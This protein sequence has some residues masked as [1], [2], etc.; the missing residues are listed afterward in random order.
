[1]SSH[2][3]KKPIAIVMGRNY[4]SRLGMI[5]AAG[6]AGCDVVVIQTEH[7]K[8]LLRP[9]DSSS[10][11]VVA[12][13][14]IPE[15]DREGLIRLI[16]SY[17][18]DGDKPVLLPTDDYT[19]ATIDMNL[20]SLRDDFLLPHVNN[21]QGAV[22]RLMDKSLQKKIALEAGMNVAREWICE[23]HDDHY[24]IPSDVSYP[25]FTKPQL[26][27]QGHLKKYQ[28]KCNTPQELERL[29]HSVEKFFHGPILV[30]DYHEISSEYAVVG[31]SLKDQ[32]LIPSVIEMKDSFHGITAI[33]TLTPISR[34][35]SMKECLSDFMRRTQLTGLFDID[36]YESG[37]KLYFNELNVRFGANGFALSNSVVNLPGL[38]LH[39]LL[40]HGLP[41]ANTPQS[42][43]SLTFANENIL[44]QMYY[45][46]LMTYRQY[47]SSQHGA[48]T[49]AI[50]NDDDK[51]PYFLFR[52][53]D[54][55]L[56]MVL[57]LKK[58]KKIIH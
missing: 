19:A 24:V 34:I 52:C 11:Y 30:E 39:N 35:P 29:L 10:K 41:V 44:R 47:R 20:D 49:F 5:R 42:F 57:L 37:G 33:G 53:V 40:G 4:T 23:W 9:I 51:L 21:E 17:K 6:T 58:L 26:S 13:Q 28:K 48:S 46:G 54:R 18:S 3:H 27:S 12:R 43:D 22:V 50:K 8:P 25:C 36:M 31:L 38:F 32:C 16:Q 55:V 45:E 7:K 1:M 15:P 56:P 14:F 2:I